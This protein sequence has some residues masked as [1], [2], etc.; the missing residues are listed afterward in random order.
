MGQFD[1]VEGALISELVA[2]LV[3]VG[4]LIHPKS[5][6]VLGDLLG[7]VVGLHVGLDQ[8]LEGLRGELA[9][10]RQEAVVV[11]L[12]GDSIEHFGLS[13]SLKNGLRFHS[14]SET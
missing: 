10:L 7:L 11:P 5:L 2:P 12:G 1:E 4:V 8:P 3:T 14:Y 9:L 13:F 6:V